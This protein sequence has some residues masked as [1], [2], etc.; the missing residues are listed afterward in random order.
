MAALGVRRVRSH[1]VQ[2]AER[3]REPVL[4]GEEVRDVRDKKRCTE[5]CPAGVGRRK[6]PGTSVDKQ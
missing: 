5:A 6:G 1:V 2:Q 3:G 4:R